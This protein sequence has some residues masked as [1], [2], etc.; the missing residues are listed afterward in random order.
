VTGRVYRTQAEIDA[1]AARHRSQQTALTGAEYTLLGALRDEGRDQTLTSEGIDRSAQ[2]ASDQAKVAYETDHVNTIRSSAFWGY[3]DSS[4]TDVPD[5]QPQFEEG[6]FDAGVMDAH[7]EATAEYLQQHGRG[8]TEPMAA[9]AI[10]TDPPSDS[11]AQPIPAGNPPSPRYSRAMLGVQ[12]S[13]ALG[14]DYNGD[15]KTITTHF[16][17]AQSTIGADS[18]DPKQ[19]QAILD[20]VSHAQPGKPVNIYVMG[21]ASADGDQ[22]RNQTYADRRA[23]AGQK[24]LEDF[25]NAHPEIKP[26]QYQIIPTSM[27]STES[28]PAHRDVQISLNPLDGKPIAPNTHAVGAGATSMIDPTN[29]AAFDKFIGG[30]NGQ[31]VTSIN[32][33]LPKGL[34][35]DQRIQAKADYSDEAK[36]QGFAGTVNFD[37]NQGVQ[38]GSGVYNTQ[39]QVFMS[40]A[41]NA[42]SNLFR[43][44]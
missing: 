18:I 33:L 6:A 30:L 36:R 20:A 27:I 35:A 8:D 43:P 19:F 14:S 40:V 42:P 29:L 24:A 7:R 15:T 31:K 3:N 34:S 16:A 21:E 44:H 22:G 1:E 17:K 26:S 39:N 12:N 2:L 25:L 28:G 41:A 4:L 23:A 5:F 11:A 37:L 13:A 38:A 9:V 10:A 32:I